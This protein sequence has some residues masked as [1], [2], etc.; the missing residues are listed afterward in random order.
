MISNLFKQFG[1]STKQTPLED[2]NT[3]IFCGILKYHTDV[4]RSFVIFLDLPEGNY[5]VNTQE[6]H[7]HATK[8]NCELDMVLES[9]DTICF[10]ENKVNSKEGWEQLERYSDVLNGLQ[11]KTYLR[12]C[13]KRNDPKTIKDHKFKQF[14]WYQIAQ[15]LEN[16]HSNLPM[17]VDYL[18]F[19]KEQQMALNT[20]LTTESSIT[21]KNFSQAYETAKLY[22]ENAKTEFLKD[23]TDCNISISNKPLTDNRVA[24]FLFN[25]FND[26]S[27]NSLIYFAINFE[28]FEMHTE[29]W[30]QND[31]PNLKSFEKAGNKVMD[32]ISN[33]NDNFKFSDCS[34]FDSGTRLARV[35]SLDT[36][37]NEENAE[38]MINDWFNKS[39]KSIIAFIE[40]SPELNWKDDLLLKTK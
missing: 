31:H 24:C 40:L 32:L 1:K 19:L 12:Y 9:D 33:G 35:K 13:T 37:I 18:I 16:N 38:Y 4:L 21:L 3:E 34:S 20:R 14:R 7:K 39:F 5:K 17:V 6:Y 8:A 27:G 30:V 10:I 28:K 23:F 15:I 2:F 25:P 11:K 26:V 29:I 22:V 36:Y